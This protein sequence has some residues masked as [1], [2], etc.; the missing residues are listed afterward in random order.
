MSRLAALHS[1]GSR[2]DAARR[3]TSAFSAAH[4][5]SVLAAS[6]SMIPRL[7][8][9]RWKLSLRGGRKETG[10]FQVRTDC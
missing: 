1:M 5:H 2:S 7:D 6:F 8:A 9:G 3:G 10:A 4:S